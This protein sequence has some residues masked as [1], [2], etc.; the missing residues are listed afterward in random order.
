[1]TRGRG[2][3]LVWLWW[4]GYNYLI[5]LE[6]SFVPTLGYQVIELTRYTVSS[7]SLDRM[8]MVNLVEVM[9]FAVVRASKFGILNELGAVSTDSKREH[10][11]SNQFHSF[12][13]FFDLKHHPVLVTKVIV[14][15]W[16]IV[17]N[18]LNFVDNLYW[19]L[20]LCCYPKQ[21]RG[22]FD[23]GHLFVYHKLQSYL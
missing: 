6:V 13:F 17:G 12:L 20:R 21:H 11:V 10:N 2:L 22:G 9:K 7:S 5:C 16:L 18:E 4:S 19:I 3:T 1:M 8:K 14:R 15:L 23:L